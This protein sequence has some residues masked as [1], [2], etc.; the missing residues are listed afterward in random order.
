MPRL[1]EARADPDRPRRA[2]AA[3]LLRPLSSSRAEQA[4]G[5]E[6]RGGQQHD[7]GGVS[8]TA[9]WQDVFD[10][11]ARWSVVHAANEEILP[12]LPSKSVGVGIQDPPYEAEA[13]TSGRRINGAMGGSARLVR[14]APVDEFPPITDAERDIVGA[15][16]A[17]LV[18]RWALTFCQVEAQHKWSAALTATRAHRYVRT[19]IYV[20]EDPQPQMTGDRPG[21]GWETIVITHP[22]GRTRWNGGGR[23]GVF[24]S[25]SGK[26]VDRRDGRSLHPT[27]KPTEL[28][29][30][31]VALFSEPD[32]IVL[33]PF[34]GVSTTGVAAIRLGRRFI[35]IEREAG[36]AALSRERLAA[37]E[38]GL[39]LRDARAG[40]LS[41]LH[42]AVPR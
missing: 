11:K 24:S 6:A 3:A 15:Q 35:G 5:C 13:H 21:M 32:E 40:Q 34:A 22:K 29:L 31:L 33:D 36:F 12:L 26:S 41:L 42:D 16:V 18:S 27:Q 28:M 10:G 2:A 14:K 1:L 38:R 7:E 23:C 17:R 25:L 20:K 9:T 19:A 37:E 4:R 30:E 39:S 8:A